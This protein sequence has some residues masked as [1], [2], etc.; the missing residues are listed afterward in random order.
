MSRMFA[1]IGALLRFILIVVNKREPAPGMRGTFPRDAD[2]PFV[3][4][5]EHKS[6]V[7][8]QYATPWL[9]MAWPF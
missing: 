2:D 3:V 1:S 8:G 7:Y 6:H 9:G 4:Q 5:L